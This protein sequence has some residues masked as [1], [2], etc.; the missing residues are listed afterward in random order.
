MMA[1]YRQQDS[2]GPEAGSAH[3]REV[4]P[5]GWTFVS[6]YR[7]GKRLHYS[8]LHETLVTID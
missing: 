2:G 7:Q 1:Q 4:G 3:G 5:N 8:S 6:Q